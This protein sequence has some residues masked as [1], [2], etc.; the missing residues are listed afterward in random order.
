MPLFRYEA[1]NEYGDQH[2]GELLA[3][4]AEDARWR[5]S[6]QNLRL[7]GISEPWKTFVTTPPRS[8]RQ[9]IRDRMRWWTYLAIAVPIICGLVIGVATFI[10][11]ASDPTMDWSGPYHEWWHRWMV[12]GFFGGVAGFIAAG[13][14][15]FHEFGF[16]LGYLLVLWISK[17]FFTA[18]DD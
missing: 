14:I 13:F 18:P 2:R 17:T 8:D 15:A 16:Y 12:S 7:R 3:W 4:D 10:I 11:F 6:A 1:L 5:L 9:K